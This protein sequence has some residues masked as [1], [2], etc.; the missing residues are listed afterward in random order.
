MAINKTFNKK[1]GKDIAISLFIYALPVVTL[2]LY[3]I[4]KGQ[5]PWINSTHTPVQF[6]APALFNFVKPV[7]ENLQSWGFIIIAFVLGILEFALG[8]YDNKWT[9]TERAIDIVCF[10]APKVLL[11]PVTAFFALKLLPFAMPHFANEFSWVPFW[12]GVF[13]IVVADDL[14]QYWYHRL[15]HQVPF[16]WRFHRTH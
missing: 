12:G 10:I 16:L 8:L 1:P 14:T 2:Y 3:F 5:T 4:L 7:F 11:V 9:K 6:N 15:H 13:I